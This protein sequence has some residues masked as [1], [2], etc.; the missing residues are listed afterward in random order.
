[1]SPA[2]KALLNARLAGVTVARDGVHLDLRA[3]AKPSAEI[4]DGLRQH[5]PAILELLSAERCKVCHRPGTPDH[6]LLDCSYAGHWLL[7]HRACIGS[8]SESEAAASDLYAPQSVCDYCGKP[9]GKLEN[10]GY[11]DGPV[12]GVPVHLEC[13]AA[14]FAR[15]DRIKNG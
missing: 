1:M 12:G 3:P 8:F 7:L 9:G 4:L 6:P 15:L 10:V 13:A 2:A 5:K 11:R 14:W